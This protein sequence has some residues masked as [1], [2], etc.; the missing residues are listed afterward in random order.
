LKLFCSYLTVLWDPIRFHYGYYLRPAVFV[1]T[2][3]HRDI[4]TLNQAIR[5]RLELD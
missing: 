5:Q 3:T 1:G 4:E 2:L